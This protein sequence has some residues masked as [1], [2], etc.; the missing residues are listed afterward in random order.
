MLTK[1]AALSSDIG[2]KKQI[3]RCVFED[4]LEFPG[5]VRGGNAEASVS[6]NTCDI[7]NCG[8]YT[9]SQNSNSTTHS[10]PSSRS[11]HCVGYCPECFSVTD[12]VNV[13]RSTMS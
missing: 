12:P 2:Q 7:N 8:R 5:R 1:N 9:F 3:S 13:P 10:L 11:S 6:V 4:K